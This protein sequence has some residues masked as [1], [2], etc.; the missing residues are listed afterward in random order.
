M[1]CCWNT[2]SA[3]SRH[4]LRPS[5]RQDNLVNQKVA[6]GMLRKLGLS[7]EIADNGAAALALISDQAA[8]KAI[9]IGRIMCVQ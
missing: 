6:C 4:P 5:P 3:R 9:V 8:M 7:V 1:D 2:G